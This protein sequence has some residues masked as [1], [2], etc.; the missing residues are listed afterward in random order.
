MAQ[1]PT[2]LPPLS[3][4]LIRQLDEVTPPAKIVDPS[5]IA[6]EHSRLQVAYE[7]GRRALVDDLL[8]LL[9]DNKDIPHELRHPGAGTAPGAR[10]FTPTT[11]YL[12]TKA[13]QRGAGDAEAEPE[14]AEGPAEPSD[15]SGDSGAR[16]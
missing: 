3:A 11:R 9:N 4:D 10:A 15:Q 16:G 14:P 1:Y 2:E 6:G 7:A 8:N 12:R 5:A 13:R